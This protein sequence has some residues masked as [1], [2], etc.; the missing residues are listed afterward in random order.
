MHFTAFIKNIYFA[1]LLNVFL[2]SFPL[3]LR[4]VKITTKFWELRSRPQR[5]ILKRLTG[6]SL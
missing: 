1:R 6:S 4:A 3:E 2:L 5:R